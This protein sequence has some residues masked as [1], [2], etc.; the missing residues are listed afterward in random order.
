[1]DKVNAYS[2]KTIF[3]TRD[4]HISWKIKFDTE[5]QVFPS[6]LEVEFQSSLLSLLL[7]LQLQ[8]RYYPCKFH[9]KVYE[10]AFLEKTIVL[11]IK[12]LFHFSLNKSHLQLHN[13]YCFFFLRLSPS[14]NFCLD[15]AL[16]FT[17]PSRRSSI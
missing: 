3:R 10:K 7:I 8:I 11:H 5:L 16:I 4:S 2:I 12:L 13:T 15:R 14:I 1:M 6:I 9:V 17:W